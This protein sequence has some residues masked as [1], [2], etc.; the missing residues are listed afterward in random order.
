MFQR[1][2]GK[3]QIGFV[4]FARRSGRYAS[5][6]PVKNRIGEFPTRTS[7][8][9]ARR[10][11]PQPLGSM[12]ETTVAVTINAL[13]CADWPARDPIGERGGVN[14]CLMSWN[15]PISEL[16][17]L[18]RVTLILFA[19]FTQDQ[20]NDAGAVDEVLGWVKTFAHDLKGVCTCE[21][22]SSVYHP[23]FTLEMKDHVNVKTE[24]A[25]KAQYDLAVKKHQQF[26]D[27]FPKEPNPLDYKDTSV[28]EHELHHVKADF[29]TAENFA[30][31]LDVLEK[32]AYSK[33]DCDA[34]L[35]KAEKDWQDKYKILSDEQTANPHKTGWDYYFPQSDRAKEIIE[36]LKK[37][38]AGGP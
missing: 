14:L 5:A 9:R 38:L 31:K 8:F 12:S 3:R 2:L 7:P 34:A 25:L 21:K 11:M 19:D 20:K 23:S 16:D 15:D 17:A 6:S 26:P 4:P 10:S 29:A 13:V 28:L 22:G 1:G 35:V 30:T 33:T 24:A 37:R 18:G 27:L 32:T 36:I